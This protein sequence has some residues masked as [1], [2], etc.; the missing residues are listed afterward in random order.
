MKGVYPAYADYTRSPPGTRK[1]KYTSRGK[2]EP[3]PVCGVIIRK[4][5]KCQ[6][7]RALIGREHSELRTYD[8]LCESCIS[9]QRDLSKQGALQVAAAIQRNSGWE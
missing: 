5:E 6:A 3:C 1:E 8:G 7:C 2:N 4:H 9:R